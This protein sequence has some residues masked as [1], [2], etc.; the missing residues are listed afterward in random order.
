MYVSVN[1]YATINSDTAIIDS[2]SPEA[3]E[4]GNKD[5][6]FFHKVSAAKLLIHI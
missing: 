6:L 4:T 2:A 5:E 1:K 3:E